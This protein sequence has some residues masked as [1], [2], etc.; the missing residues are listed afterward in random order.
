MGRGSLPAWAVAG[1]LAGALACG[2]GYVLHARVAAHPILDLRLLRAQTFAAATFGGGLCRLGFGAIPFLLAMLL[3]VGFGLTPLAAGLLSFA[4]AA[5]ALLNKVAIHPIVRWFGFRSVLIG[6]ASFN[7]LFLCGYAL[8]RPT[9]PH[10]IIIVTLLIGGFFRSLLFTSLNTLGYA[11][12]PSKQLGRATSLAS[13]AQQ[14]SLSLGVGFAALLLH[15]SLMLRGG[16]ELATRDVSPAFL[17]VGLV[18]LASLPWF[19][20]LPRLAGAEVSGGKRG[21]S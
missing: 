18:S 9:T 17:V 16:M 13:T 12:I 10:V 6:T 19:F 5:G 4:G 11:D 15:G 2:V 14:V 8:F 3:Q 7:G 21:D 20:R 1:M